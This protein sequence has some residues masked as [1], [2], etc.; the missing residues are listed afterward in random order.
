MA[1]EGLWSKVGAWFRN[2]GVDLRDFLIGLRFAGIIYGPLDKRLSL[3]EILEKAFQRPIPPHVNWFFCFGGIT[4]FLFM[5][6][7]VTGTL[8]ALYYK[9]TPAEAYASIKHIVNDVPLGWFIRQIHAWAANL[10]V[11]FMLLHMLRVFLHGAYKSPR[12]LNWVVGVL[13]FFIT[14]IF[15]FTGYLLP[16]D[17]WA[18][19]GTKGGSETLRGIPL[20]GPQILHLLWG[21]PN[22]T[23]TTLIRFYAI[24][25]IVLPWLIT[26]FLTLHF[27]MIRRQRISEP[28]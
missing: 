17:Q 25:V 18:Y 16:W 20:F 10:M 12:E 3:R 6:Q 21:G 22:V 24:H 13:L 28:L 26:L 7:I 11:F 4:L 1:K 27:L 19:W 14:L 23:G 2:R 9:P 15:G 5:I 8:L